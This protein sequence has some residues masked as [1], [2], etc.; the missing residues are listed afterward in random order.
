MAKRLQY[1]RVLAL[2]LVLCTGL[3]G[4][5]GRL[6]YLQV[7]R[8]DELRALARA[9]TEREFMREPKRGDILDVK[10]NLLA[11]SV[12]VKTVCANPMAISNRQSDVARALAP[13]LQMSEADLYRKMLP[14]YLTN[15]AGKLAPRLSV[16]LKEKVS[17]ETWDKVRGVM[18]NLTFGVNEKLLPKSQRKFYSDLRQTAIFCDTPDSQMRVYP[19]SNLCAHV[20]GYTGLSTNDYNGKIVNITVGADGIE[21]TMNTKLEGVRGWRITEA[22]NRNREVVWLRDQDVEPHDGCNVALTI[23]S[24]IQNIAEEE[25][26]VGMQKFSPISITAIV[27]RPKTGEILAMATLPTFDPNNLRNSTADVRRNRV[28]ADIVEPGST[29]KIVVVSG[30]LNEGKAKLTD[31]FFCENGAFAYGGRILHDHEKYPTLSMEQIITKSSNIGAAKIAIERLG[32]DDL[33]NYMRDFG[34]GQ[35]TGV[36][37]PGEV[38]GI[39]WPVSK[40]SK[41]SIAQIPMGHGVC[42]TRLQMAMAMAALAN[43]GML[44]RP[45]LVDRLEDADGNILGKYGPQPLRQVISTNACRDMVQ[46]LK[47]VATKDGTA[48]T[49]AM[50]HYTVAGKTGTAQ[51][52]EGGA[53]VNKFI[54]SFIG[55]FPAD[56]P[57][58][59]ISVVLDDPKGTHYG[60]QTAAPVFKKIAER[61]ASY[62]NIRPD[63]GEEPG[64]PMVFETG[65]VGRAVGTASVR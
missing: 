41:V 15:A 9:N 57:E 1:Y 55:F 17:V 64:R 16:R 34:F 62:L 40:W 6:V 56:E 43:H 36:L 8:H 13:V 4:L 54:S 21:R 46:A 3:F 30:A 65:T 42:V 18:S 32:Q 2:V 20:L 44:M 63:R 28:I 60:G 19:N 29:F 47:T 38:G 37:L 12:F 51:K 7:F 45:M 61:T 35:R 10:G 39:V 48:A 50:E 49:A 59:C 24:V 33:F 26:R 52:V 22:D 11:T 31:K 27:I 14:Q 53:Y 5:A 58:L 23:D 25:C